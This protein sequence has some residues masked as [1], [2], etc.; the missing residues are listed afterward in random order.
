MSDQAQTEDMVTSAIQDLELVRT[1]RLEI[2][3]DLT[4][5]DNRSKTIEDKGKL[6]L[7][8]GALAD[9]DR[10]AISKIRVKNDEKQANKEH[11]LSAALVASLLTQIRPNDVKS[12][13][14]DSSDIA[15]IKGVTLSDE[16]PTGIYIEGQLDINSKPETYVSFMSRMD[17]D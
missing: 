8:L 3:K 11:E 2:I 6:S 13:V 14:S 5:G 15:D 16:I 7:L 10:I 17:R 12:R 4:T 9:A 1:T